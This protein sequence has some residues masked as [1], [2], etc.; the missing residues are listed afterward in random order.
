MQTF[1]FDLPEYQNVH[2]QIYLSF[3]TNKPTVTVN[4][5]PIAPTFDNPRAFLLPMPDHTNVKLEFK[6]FTID[7]QPRIFI[8]GKMISIASKLRWYAWIPAILPGFLIFIGGALGGLCAFVGVT[9]NFKI[10]RSSQESFIKMIAV[11]GTTIGSIL[12]YA[13]LHWILSQIIQWLR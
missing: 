10:L 8:N 11:L 13:L 2:V 5:T 4:G 6:G 7:Y 3:W 9:T 1:T 12:G